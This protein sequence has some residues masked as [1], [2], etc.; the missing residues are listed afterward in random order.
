MTSPKRV[1]ITGAA[2]G[3]GLACVHKFAGDGYTVL[4]M[5]LNEPEDTSLFAGFEQADATDESAIA[6]VID[7]F[8]IPANGLDVLV[9]SAGM[10]G[11]GSVTEIDAAF[12]TKILT[13]NLT[14]TFLITRAVI[15][16]MQ[17]NGGGAIVT[18]GSTFAMMGR[19][20]MTGYAVSKA[21]VAH[22]TRCLAIDYAK[23][24]IRA[25][26]VCPGLVDTPMTSHL[27][28]PGREEARA[29][30]INAHPMKRSGTPEEIAETITFLASPAASYI[31]GQV[32]G[33]DGGFTAGK[34]VLPR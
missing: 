1:L 13:V 20:A 10:T 19:D 16:H 23:D 22:L 29:A 27:N 11:H 28:A 7:A 8:E 26:C 6:Q 31:T 21:G 2:S 18:I 5:D 4:G 17:K 12:W 25:N 33:V 14:S 24:G 32:I 34:Q 15:P 9:H 30:L 3:I